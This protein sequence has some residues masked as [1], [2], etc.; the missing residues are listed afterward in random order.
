MGGDGHL[1]HP[2]TLECLSTLLIPHPWEYP[3]TLLNP[4]PQEYPTTL[5]APRILLGQLTRFTLPS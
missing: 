4:D 1:P 2:P 5:P 3:C